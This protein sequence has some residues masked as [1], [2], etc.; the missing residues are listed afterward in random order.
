MGKTM[1]P[2][3]TVF[4]SEGKNSNELAFYHY[5]KHA[6]LPSGCYGPT[7][8]DYYLF[9]FIVNGKGRYECGG[10]VFHL[11]K[12]QGF[13]IRPGEESF[14][15]A[16]EQ[17]P[18]EY[19]FVAF[20]GTRAESMVKG[21]NWTDGY[22]VSPED[23]RSV[24]S[25]MKK[26]YAVKKSERWGE[27]MV[28]GYLYTLLATLAKE[29]FK[30]VDPV[31]NSEKAEILNRAMDF[32]NKNF[33]EGIKIADVANEVNMHRTTLYRL[34][35]EQLNVSVEKY[36]Q[37]CR[38]DRAV[39]LLINSDLPASA[40]SEQVGMFDYPH[41]CKQFKSYYGFSPTDYRKKFGKN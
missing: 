11:E 26:I 24:K 36:I 28:L 37:N 32:I 6:C 20:H 2:V 14:Y 34:F 41:F 10:K 39:F 4:F 27:Y 22:I 23:S 18:W 17:E 40:I 33:S 21:I 25:I 16:N 30:E 13:L 31:I 8:R 15:Q 9:H 12:N 3:P 35:K 5:G 19:Y 7:K 1:Q 29:S 38:M